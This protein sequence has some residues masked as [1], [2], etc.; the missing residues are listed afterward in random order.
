MMIADGSYFVVMFLFGKSWLTDKRLT[1]CQ[2][3]QIFWL[4]WV[5]VAV[6]RLSLTAASRG[7][8]LVAVLGLLLLLSTSS[9]ALGLRLLQQGGS[10]AMAH[11][12]NCPT[13]CGVFLGQGLNWCPLQ[14]KAES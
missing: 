14:R 8:S 9:R 6:F 10:V 5:F 4:L 3:I 13:A 2:H 7:S 1:F 12:I 11:G